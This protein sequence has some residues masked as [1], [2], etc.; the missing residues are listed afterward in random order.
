[1]KLN[2]LR[3][4]I[5]SIVLLLM[6]TSFHCHFV[7]QASY[8]ME[9][10]QSLRLIDRLTAKELIKSPFSDIL[11]IFRSVQEDLTDKLKPYP[12][13]TASGQKVWS[14]T[15]EYSVLG[16]N[17]NIIPEGME[18]YLDEH[19]LGFWADSSNQEISWKWVETYQDL[20]L[21]FDD[22]FNPTFQCVILEENKPLSFDAYFPD[23]P[24]KMEITARRNWHP[25]DLDIQIDGQSIET[26]SISRSY[27]TFGVP[28]QASAGTH[29]LILTPK[30]S[31]RIQSPDRSTP[32][33]LLISKV[34]ILTQNDLILFFVPKTKQEEFLAGEIKAMYLSDQTESGE[35]HSYLDYFR[36]KHSFVLDPYEQKQNPEKIKKKITRDNLSIDVLMAPPE[37]QYAFE[38]KIPPSSSLEFGT[39]IYND[40]KIEEKL[41]V[42][43]KVDLEAKGLRKQ[44]YENALVLNS[45]PMKDQLVLE[46]VDL[47]A[48][49]GK[50]VKLTFTTESTSSEKAVLSFWVN[51]VI[52][53]PSFENPKII[54]ISLDTLRADHLGCYGYDRETSP[55][56]DTLA[57]ESILFT[58][59]YAQ[60][61]WTLP[62]HVSMLFSLNS[63]SHQVYY[64]DQKI[65]SSLPSIANFLKREGYLT[66]A[67]TSGGYVSSIFGFAKGFDWYDEPLDKSKDPLGQYEAERL[68]AHTSEWLRNNKDKP[69]FLFLHT[70]QTHGPYYCPSP[71]NERFLEEK[72]EWTRMDLTQF[73]ESRG[74]NYTFSPEEIAN[75]VSLYD[76]EIRYTDDMLIKP[77]VS[78]LKD[79]N[80]YDNTLIIITSDHGEEFHDHEGWLHGR[81]LYEESIRVPLIIKFPNSEFKGKKL[82]ANCSLIDIMPTILEIASVKYNKKSIEGK[83]LMDM[84]LDKEKKSR[85]FISDLAHRDVPHPCPSLI[86]SND[87]DLK[88]IIEKSKESIKSIKVYN[89]QNDPLEKTDIF[90]DHRKWAREFIKK[91]EDYYQDKKKILRK[92]G[93]IKMDKAQE[94]RLRALG[95]LR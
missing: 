34:R 18:L 87:G 49:A 4:L 38:V 45:K 29:R 32:P 83:S 74:D 78:L 42:K 68:Y 44:L 46:Q 79:L 53:Q 17:E 19:N 60:S 75:V 48:F 80:I 91:I 40:K 72:A 1:M 26:K 89:L 9:K 25:I 65:D 63:A 14:A 71:W 51:P 21:Q 82:T 16:H 41:S 27:Q 31:N 12:E 56:L 39:G 84:V 81:N 95:Y 86:A 92:I 62:S 73:F 10:P 64:P 22:S 11:Q 90:R 3:F 69:F 8:K 35:D 30:I 36:M 28:I 5:I 66:Y 59:T 67:M 37:S 7:K 20:N 15:T 58:H 23:A 70:Y 52:I 88:V 57:Q 24:V 2:P 61:S 50:K 76:G 77:L 6:Y 94:E 55:N 85:S 93:F 33:R 54:L 43:F 47:S 13:A